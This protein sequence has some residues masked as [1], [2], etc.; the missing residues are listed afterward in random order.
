[1]V[2]SMQEGGSQR[3]EHAK[4]VFALTPVEYSILDL[5]FARETEVGDSSTS[6]TLR[7][8]EVLDRLQRVHDRLSLLAALSGSGTLTQL[9][10]IDV[11]GDDAFLDRRVSLVPEVWTRLV[12]LPA[13]VPTRRGAALSTLALSPPVAART[14]ALAQ[15]LAEPK[16]KW[17]TVIVHGP[18]GT[19]RTAV[20]EGLAAIL[21]CDVL[22][23]DG[24]KLT[25]AA[26]PAVRREIAWHQAIALVADADRAEPAVLTALAA[27]AAC[28]LFVTTAMPIGEALLAPTRTVRMI[29]LEPLGV[30]ERAAVWRARLAAH[31]LDA[32]SLDAVEL[33]SRFRFGP[34][35]IASVVEAFAGSVVPTQADVI[36]VCRTVPKLQAGGLATP[37]RSRVGWD[38]LVVPP[39]TRAELELVVAW[40]RRRGHLFRQG[41][42]GE[43]ARAPKGVSC[44][45]YGD[46]G[47]GK[48]LAAQ[49]IAGELDREL[50][51]VD[52]SQVVDK[53]IGE[54]EKRLDNVFREAEAAGVVLLFDEADAL[55]AQRTSV[56]SSNDRYANLET[57]Y[58][59][60]RIED[61]DGIVLLATNLRGNLDP[62]FQRRL[63][64]TIEF[65]TP[66]L[67]ERRR[68][69]DLLLPSM[70]MRD[71]TID[72]DQLA[73][74]SHHLTGGDIRNAVV[75]ALLFSDQRG[76]TLGM[77]HLAI[78]IW[79]EL[80]RAGRMIEISR[81]GPWSHSVLAHANAHAPTGTSVPV[82]SR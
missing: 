28:P 75:T 81:F 15:W 26:L 63:A 48:T 44:L 53:Y 47:T 56:K 7:V 70:A 2:V 36:E 17:P 82:T 42:A 30:S 33:A 13:I 71:S 43:N 3:L 11:R 45:F 12:G 77:P 58:L 50:Y 69:W 9:A 55:F 38:A 32:A 61:H 39:A 52:L 67:A 79:R 35:R 74:F 19:G 72:L 14:A 59:L 57:G 21:G 76:A 34:A 23:I 1:M 78:A 62:A 27:R 49:L 51:R 29:D 46:P 5:V 24:T 65:P 18:A 8:A 41:A 20:A 16:T 60:Q 68:I 4:R 80:R 25:A 31:E 64:A 10:L 73:V 22:P 6:R 37:V 54:T 66:E 40:E